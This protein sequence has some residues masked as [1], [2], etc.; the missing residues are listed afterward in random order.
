MLPLLDTHQHL[1][2]RD[3]FS[4]AWA[5]GVPALAEGSYTEADYSKLAAEAGIA[6]AIFMEAAVDEPQELDE[7]R[8]VHG[9]AGDDDNL[10]RAVIAGCYPERDEGFVAYLEATADPAYVS[11]RRILH[12]VDDGVSQ[13]DTFRANVRKI[14][15]AGKAFDVCV[16]QRQLGIAYD[17]AAACDNTTLILD[18]C[19]VPDI[20]GGD[21]DG[22]RAGI[23]RIAGLPHVNCKVSGV[24]AY[25]GPDQDAET[26][27]R[28]YVEHVIEAF[29]WD[30]VVWGSDWPVVNLGLDLPGWA[31]ITR[32]IVAGEDEANQAKLFSANARRIYRLPG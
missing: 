10:T 8:F 28:P 23:D 13:T 18:H 24:V 5:D 9:L 32:R 4:Y 22:W 27:V 7:A 19:G 6:D 11:Y 30:R 31:A 17:L 21:F 26:T 3:R 20:A 14:G 29:G 1:I 16:L 12:V 15:A 2:Y 25:V